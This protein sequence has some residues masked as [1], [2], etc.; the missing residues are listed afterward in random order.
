MNVTTKNVQKNIGIILLGVII[1]MAL[2]AMLLSGSKSLDV[3]YDA[4]AVY[5]ESSY[6][7]LVGIEYDNTDRKLKVTEEKGFQGWIFLNN[8]QKYNYFIIETT[9][10]ETDGAPAVF[11]FYKGD[12]NVQ[13]MV[14]RLENGENIIPIYRKDANSVY[15]ELEQGT[16]YEYNKIQCRENLSVWDATK[17]LSYSILFFLAYI[18][19]VIIVKKLLEKRKI[20][21]P[22]YSVLEKLEKIYE[23]AAESTR[24]CFLFSKKKSI[25]ILRRVL[26]F[27]LFFIINFEEKFELS[28]VETSI[29]R[30]NVLLYSVLILVITFLSVEK[31]KKV[32]R[33]DNSLVYSW[34]FFSVCMIMS[35]FI[36]RKHFE[37]IGILFI[38]LFGFFYYIW[39]N[40]E[41]RVEMMQD[42]CQAI[43]WEFWLDIGVCFCFFPAVGSRYCGS[44]SNPNVYAINLLVPLTVFFAELA[45]KENSEKTLLKKMLPSVGIGIITYML[46]KTQCRTAF[47][48]L[49]LMIGV[50]LLICKREKVLCEKRG[51]K[52]FLCVILLFILGGCAGHVGVT[53]LPKVQKVNQAEEVVEYEGS[54]DVFINAGI[55]MKV[56]AAEPEGN[57]IV[58]KFLSSR[59]FDEF[60]SGRTAFWKAYLRQMNLWGH[61]FRA[62]V[63]GNNWQ[64]HNVFLSIAYEYGI[65]S[66]VAYL[67]WVV[68]Y[69]WYALAYFVKN[70]K[71]KIYAAFPLFLIIGIF[72]V[73]FF[74][75]LEQPFR[76]EIWIVMYLVVGVLFSK[77]SEESE[78]S[79]L[80]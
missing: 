62:Q 40:M 77:E 34:F 20:H 68:C 51:R 6:N 66:V 22:L 64:A 38:S 65:L 69:A 58:D 60:T 78:N 16:E 46:W 21:I 41:N 63:N 56:E 39:G 50:M 9:G 42:L 54:E 23:K 7:Y 43:K 80:I 29:W 32:L 18:I 10:L 28:S 12:Q 14:T 67:Y 37:S 27:L 79:E 8:L 11:R 17:F 3:F 33:W 45:E 44:Y 19:I 52:K 36:V 24:M 2:S 48:G 47:L 53:A 30:R 26:F 59:S 1:S 72:P 71:Q 35:N 61:R 49:V 76:W 13:V 15:M 74:E 25:R 75:N 57:R 5:E 73:F 70:G 31:G 4:G 55:V